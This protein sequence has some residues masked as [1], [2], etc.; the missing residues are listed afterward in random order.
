MSKFPSISAAFKQLVADT[1]IELIADSTVV[2]PADVPKKLYFMQGNV[3]EVN[4]RL[5]SMT[6][7]GQHKGKKF[8]LVVLF[9]D[10]KER[11]TIDGIEFNCKVGIFTLTQPTYTADEREEKTFIPILRPIF[12]ELLNQFSVS[13][14]FGQPTVKD[15]EIDKWDC[16]F[17][18]SVQGNKNQFNDKVDAIEISNIKLKLG[19]ETCLFTSNF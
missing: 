17:Y 16:F 9:R 5:Q 7:S 14:A 13:K 19:M 2:F 6:N 1:E 11:I 4:T 12:E 15:M 8:P 18:G 3:V 10:I